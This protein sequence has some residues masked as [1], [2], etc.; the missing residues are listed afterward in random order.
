MSKNRFYRPKNGGSD[1]SDEN[2]RGRLRELQKQLEAEKR[3]SKSLEK[4]LSK[5][6]VKPGNNHKLKEAIPK[7]EAKIL[8]QNCGKDGTLIDQTI[9]S[10]SK[11]EIVWTVCQLCHHKEKKK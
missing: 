5:R 4:A 6:T 10:P 11:G 8:C 3:Y 2:L 9:W 7:M 1:N